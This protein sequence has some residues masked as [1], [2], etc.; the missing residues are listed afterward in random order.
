MPTEDEFFK[1]FLGNLTSIYN[2][3]DFFEK[4]KIIFKV[5]N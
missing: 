3:V 4:K 5:N 1:S 2:L